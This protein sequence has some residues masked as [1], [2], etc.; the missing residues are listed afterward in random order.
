MRKIILLFVLILTVNIVKAE[1]EPDVRLTYDSATSQTSL[2]RDQ[3]IAAQGNFVHVVWQDKRD[4]NLEIYYKRSTDQG[5]TWGDDVRITNDT[6]D[7]K[8]PGI[9]LSDNNVYIIFDD[10]REGNRE[11]YFKKSTDYGNTWGEDVR[12]T[13]DN[14]AS[15]CPSI[16]VSNSGVHVVWADERSGY[17]GD[18]YYK[19]STDGGDSWSNDIALCNEIGG[20]YNVSLS[21]YNSNVNVV[22]NDTRSS[23]GQIFYIRSTDGGNSWTEDINISYLAALS[24]YPYIKSN[25]KTNDLHLVWS[26]NIIGKLQIFYQ[27]STNN[28]DFWIDD[29]CL[30]NDKEN[31]GWAALDVD[32][33]NVHVVWQDSRSGNDEIF[34]RKSTDNGKTWSDELLLTDN[35]V[36]MS[37]RP[38]IAISGSV[39]HVL[40]CDFRDGPGGEIYYKRNPTGNPVGVDEEYKKDFFEI[41]PNPADDFIL[42]DVDGK[43]FGKIQVFSVLGK[44]VLE[45][46]I[47]DRIDVSMLHSGMYYFMITSGNNIVRKKFV[48]MR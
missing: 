34:Y 3:S 9:A 10:E 6:A 41:Y 7:T 29:V 42:L 12:L 2:N 23:S 19:K 48:I 46:E 32:N 11:I 31:S 1:W 13:F 15:W 25:P 27:H 44:K 26:Q 35:M 5:L 21:V 36:T 43:Q 4:G 47:V 24:W 40:W 22:W 33:S 45:T 20:S 18:I 16:E 37:L 30:R 8:N 39:V 14:S 17:Q 38:Y 28:G